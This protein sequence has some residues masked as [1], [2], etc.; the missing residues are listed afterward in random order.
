MRDLADTPGPGGG[1]LSAQLRVREPGT[2]TTIYAGPLAT[3]PPQRLGLLAPGSPRSFEF[4]ANPDGR[5]PACRPERRSGRRDQR[6]LRLDG[7]RTGT[8]GA[9]R[10][11]RRRAA[12]WRRRASAPGRAG[13]PSDLA[14]T[15]VRHRIKGGRLLVW[16]SELRPALRPARPRP[17]AGPRRGRPPRRWLLADP[18]RER[19]RARIELLA[20]DAN[21]DRDR[22]R[23]SLRVS[24]AR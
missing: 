7:G 3:M 23:R 17:P 21:G 22:V 6:R 14:L 24:S 4:V 8:G 12:G 10:A 20:W 2:G 5:R 9:A 16:V 18:S 11:G 13:R 19:G 15:K 1:V